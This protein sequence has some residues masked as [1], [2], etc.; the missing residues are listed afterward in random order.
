MR[1]PAPPFFSSLR[2]RVFLLSVA[3]LREKEERIKREKED[4]NLRKGANY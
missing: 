1:L 4:A 2:P 3:T